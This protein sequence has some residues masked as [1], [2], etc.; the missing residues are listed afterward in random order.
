M[1]EN[2]QRAPTPALDREISALADGEYAARLDLRS[3]VDADAFRLELPFDAGI[4]N[5]GGGIHGGALVSVLMAAARVSAAASERGQSERRP[6][7]LTANVAFLSVPRRGRLVARAEVVRRGREIA[8]ASAT[9]VD[10]D[11]VSVAAGA[12]TIGFVD[13]SAREQSTAEQGRADS[14]IDLS[15]GNPVS[16]SPYLAAAGV[17]VLPPEGPMAR[18]WLPQERNRASDPRRV[19]EG[20]IAGLADSCAAYAAHLQ[21]PQ[22]TAQG[23]L[24]VSLA[25]TFHTE[26]AADLIGTGVVK[27]GGAGC[28]T[29]AVEVASGVGGIPVA[30][31][32]AVYRL[33]G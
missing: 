16:G 24:T 13:S 3:Q 23:G 29:A 1:F 32:F 17:L 18:I 8:H 20:A 33:P 28:C 22:A 11:G 10:Q 25:L 31:G 30:S 14:C 5:R 27:G 4:T 6:R 9:A 2:S 15:S 19:D 12:M 26:L 7:L 21:T